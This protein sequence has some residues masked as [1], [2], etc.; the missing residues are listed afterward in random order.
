MVSVMVMGAAV[1][2]VVYGV[3][4][5]LVVVWCGFF[6]VELLEVLDAELLEVALVVV[7]LLEVAF[8]VV[9][10]VVVLGGW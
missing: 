3:V 6:V 10:V 9:E 2:V 1:V 8:V 7:E 5:A 4:V